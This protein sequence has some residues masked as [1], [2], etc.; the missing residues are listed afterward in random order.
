MIQRKQTVYLLLALVITVVCLCLPVGTLVPQGMGVDM[1]V[2]NLWIVDGNGGHDFSVW[3]TFVLLLLTCPII[4]AAILAYKNR[5]IQTRL[6]DV[7]FF[8]LL[9]WFAVYAYHYFTLG[10][11]HHAAF[12]MEFAAGLPFFSLILHILARKGIR[13]DEALVRSMDRIR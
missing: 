4:L 3:G 8:L 5:R 1:P 9:C 12:Q 11:P 13:A 7:N 2:Y 10:E 6:C